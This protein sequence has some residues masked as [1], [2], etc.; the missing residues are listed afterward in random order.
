MVSAQLTELL[1]GTSDRSPEPTTTIKKFTPKKKEKKKK[2]K[3]NVKYFRKNIL[4]PFQKKCHLR[5]KF[6]SQEKYTF[7]FLV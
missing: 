1:K 2:R 6:L 4:F 5:I 3:P 7:I